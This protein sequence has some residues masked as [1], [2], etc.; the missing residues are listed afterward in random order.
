M[1]WRL[2]THLRP[3]FSSQLHYNHGKRRRLPLRIFRYTNR[4]HKGAC[5]TTNAE[6]DPSVLTTLWMSQ[7]GHNEL[8]A[9]GGTCRLPCAASGAQDGCQ[10]PPVAGHRRAPTDQD[11][12]VGK[13]HDARHGGHGRQWWWLSAE[14]S[15]LMSGGRH[16]PD[17]TENWQR[18][19]DSFNPYSHLNCVYC[20]LA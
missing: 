16:V 1:Q 17:N 14:R 11:S 3:G 13:P 8:I 15:R 6:M 12:H 7:Y 4:F 20:L 10:Q 18:M 5:A 2:W 19:I 9:V